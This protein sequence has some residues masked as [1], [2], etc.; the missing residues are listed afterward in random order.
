MTPHPCCIQH[1]LQDLRCLTLGLSSDIW[2]LPL[3][4]WKVHILLTEVV[5]CV[6]SQ[7]VLSNL[8]PGTCSPGVSSSLN[9][10]TDGRITELNNMLNFNNMGSFTDCNTSDSKWILD[11][12]RYNDSYSTETTSTRY[13]SRYYFFW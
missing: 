11:R 8:A 6:I 1:M 9:H 10:S 7:I 5:V 3:G 2:G 4:C 13:F 12:S